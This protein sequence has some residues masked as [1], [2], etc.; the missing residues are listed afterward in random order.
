MLIFIY[1]KSCYYGYTTVIFNI[2]N[3]QSAF[4][5]F[6]AEMKNEMGGG[7]LAK[8]MIEAVRQAELKAQ[9]TEKNAEVESSAILRQAEEQ[10]NKILEESTKRAKEQAEKKKQEVIRQDEEFTK[11]LL[12][13]AEQEI[14]VLHTHAQEKE[15]EA[16]RLILSELL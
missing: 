10:A 11:R 13:E 4:A 6:C 1:N 2:C 15:P 3:M 14:A 7:K 9:E 12:L 5:V 8:E 16:I